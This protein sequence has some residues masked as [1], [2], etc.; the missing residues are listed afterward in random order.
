VISTLLVTQMKDAPP[1]RVSPDKSA[2]S[3]TEM[4]PVIP[5]K[6]G[7]PSK[8][9]QRKTPTKPAAKPA[10]NKKKKQRK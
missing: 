5:A 10:R 1:Q 8:K 3:L 4:Q 9:P 7:N 6:P 2:M